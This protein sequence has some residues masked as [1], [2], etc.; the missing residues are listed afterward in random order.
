[1][2]LFGKA[3]G[4]AALAALVPYRFQ[5]DKQTGSFELGALL[6]SLKKK[7]GEEKDV[8]TIEFLPFMG[9]KEAEDTAE[10]AAEGA[11]VDAADEP[12]TEDLSEP[13]TEPLN[14]EPAAAAE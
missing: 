2:K 13:V 8:Y 14:E 10:C 5:S 6:W 4:A 12:V 3:L 9:K 7:P 1:M 11:E